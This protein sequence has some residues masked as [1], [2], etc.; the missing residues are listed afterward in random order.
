MEILIQNI[1]DKSD[2]PEKKLCPVRVEWY[3]V[4]D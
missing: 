4:I 1:L 3:T 2:F